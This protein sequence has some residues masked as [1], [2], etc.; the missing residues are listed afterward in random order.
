MFTQAIKD[1]VVRGAIAGIVLALHKM[2]ILAD[3]A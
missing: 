1:D 2:G 3:E